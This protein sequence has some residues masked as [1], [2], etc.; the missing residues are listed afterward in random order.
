MAKAKGLKQSHAIGEVQA[1]VEDALIHLIAASGWVVAV[2]YGQSTGHFCWVITPELSALNDGESYP[3]AEEALASGRTLVQC[4][5]GLQVDF[6]R[7][8]LFE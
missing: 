5:T 4:S 1:T 7:C 3:T 8:R 2:T 6:S